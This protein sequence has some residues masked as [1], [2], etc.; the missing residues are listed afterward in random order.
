LPAK[1]GRVVS[2]CQ[3]CLAA[4]PK[5]VTYMYNVTKKW[6]RHAKTCPGLSKSPVLSREAANMVMHMMLGGDC[7]RQNSVDAYVTAYWV[8]KHKLAFTTGD[9]LREIRFTKINIHSS[10]SLQM[11]FCFVISIPILPFYS[12]VAMYELRT[13]KRL[14]TPIYFHNVH[15]ATWPST[16][17]IYAKQNYGKNGEGR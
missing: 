2:Q 16:R 12:V 4:D 13:K 8:Y 6:I 9:K 11:F 3:S 10:V 17:K 1:A 14:S 7:H 5:V 15:T